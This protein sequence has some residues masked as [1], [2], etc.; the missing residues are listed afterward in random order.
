[1]RVRLDKH[2]KFLDDFDNRL[3]ENNIMDLSHSN[4]KRLALEWYGFEVEVDD[5]GQE[6]VVEMP[7]ES[8]TMFALKYS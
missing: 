5:Y 1:M 3:R 2:H 8:Y 7:E 4:I 6:A